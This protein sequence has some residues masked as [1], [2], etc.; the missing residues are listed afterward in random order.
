MHRKEIL[1]NAIKHTCGERDNEYGSPGYNLENTA[2]LWREYLRMKNPG[3]KLTISAEDVA[4]LNMLQK[5]SRRISGDSL[6]H[7]D[8]FEDMAAYAAIAG[9]LAE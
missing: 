1:E 4:I 2:T 7:M 5:V 8:T 3:F 9:E 6:P